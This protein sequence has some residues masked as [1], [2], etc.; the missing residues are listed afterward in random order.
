VLYRGIAGRNFERSFQLADHVLGAVFE[1]VEERLRVL[2]AK[3]DDLERVKALVEFEMFRP[4]LEA[5][6]PRADRTK[7]GR[8][9]F[10]HVLMCP[11]PHPWK[12]DASNNS[13]FCG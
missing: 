3:G 13:L 4:A 1:D 8:P 12:L 2:S 9:A 11:E 6:V 10:D 7:G 5:A